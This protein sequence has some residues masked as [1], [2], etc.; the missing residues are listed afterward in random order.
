MTVE[1]KTSL[2]EIH[3]IHWLM[4][5]VQTID[6]GLIIINNEHRVSLWNGF[7]EN[8]SG[9]R[10]D[11]AQGRSIFELFSELNEEWFRNKTDAVF[12]LKSR[13]FTSWEQRPYVFKFK[14]NR[15]ITSNVPYMYQ[16][17]SIIP[18]SSPESSAD[19]ACVIVYDVTDIA[20]NKL[21]LK[22]A[23]ERLEA[24]NRID[25]LTQLFNRSYWESSLL[26]EY[27]RF[28]RH[29]GA[30]S[31]L[32]MFD[33]DHFKSVNDQY[34]HQAG[35]A[36]IR[37]VS[38]T[39]CESLRDSDIAGRYGGEEFGV[40]LVE[41]NSDQALMYAERLRECVEAKTVVFDGLDIDVTVSIGVSEISSEFA[42]YEQWIIKADEALYLAKS[43]GRNCS[44][45]M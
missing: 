36:V 26:K 18:V 35:D 33:I 44:R 38:Q 8:H 31:S 17:I 40:I 13:T 32:L 30:P 43:E 34:G 39:L 9:I 19:H 7:I 10:A 16:N 25:G 15:P 42:R 23:N 24:A 21:A 37:M 11:Q 1:E 45:V 41:T 14:N 3:G 6:V 20:V 29:G 2:L 12:L 27:E 22:K 5:V 4:D 28:F